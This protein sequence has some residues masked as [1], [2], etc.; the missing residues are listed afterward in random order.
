MSKVV[1]FHNEILE[2]PVDSDDEEHPTNCTDIELAIKYKKIAS[3]LKKIDRKQQ[4]LLELYV[5]RDKLQGDIDAL[6]DASGSRYTPT[7]PNYSPTSPNYSPTSPNYLPV[8]PCDVPTTTYF[9]LNTPS[10]SP[11]DDKDDKEED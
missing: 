11:S 6:L 5:K 10:Y 2:W 3:V 1:A 9:S 8:S 4:Q 7:S